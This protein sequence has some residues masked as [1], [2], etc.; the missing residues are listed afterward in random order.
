MNLNSAMYMQSQP[1]RIAS[2]SIIAAAVVM[3]MHTTSQ[4][5]S[6]VPMMLDVRCSRSVLSVPS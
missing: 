3:Q 6:Q 1:V 5:L 4:V 2:R